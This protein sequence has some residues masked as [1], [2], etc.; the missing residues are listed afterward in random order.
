MEKALAGREEERAVVVTDALFSV[1][2]DLAPVAELSE[3]AAR[4]GALLVVDEAHSLGVVGEHGRGVVHSTGLFRESHIVRTVTL[5]KAL[6]SQGGAVLGEP[7]VIETLVDTGRSFIFDTG[8][9]PASVA[10]ASAAVDILLHQP[11][12]PRRARLRAG[13]L[14]RAV[15][16]LGLET[17]EP[18]GAVVPVVLGAPGTAVLA[19]AACAELGVR[20]GCL[21]PPSV[22]DGRSCLRLTARANLSSDDLAVIRHALTA[23]AE[24]KVRA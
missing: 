2:G 17:S 7:E 14:A 22:P 6:G 1:E 3:V 20:V 23:V 12:L 16:E 15:R 13:E 24:V 11:E 21:R 4:H 19:A 10:A 8:L 18:A 5:S 9:A